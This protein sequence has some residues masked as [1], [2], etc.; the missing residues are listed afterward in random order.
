MGN[1]STLGQ[2]RYCPVARRS[3]RKNIILFQKETCSLNNCFANVSSK[4]SSPRTLPIIATLC[5][6][7]K[8]MTAIA[9]HSLFKPSVLSAFVPRISKRATQTIRKPVAEF[10]KISFVLKYDVAY[11]RYVWC[12]VSKQCWRR[13]ET[14]HLTF[15]YLWIF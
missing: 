12:R 1:C 8:S 2:I 10:I 14:C 5:N 11:T 15:K 3:S 4:A 13:T 9:N 6:R 7:H